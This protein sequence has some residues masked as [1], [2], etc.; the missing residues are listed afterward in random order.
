MNTEA[1]IKSTDFILSAAGN[2]GKFWLCV[3]NESGG[4]GGQYTRSE[5]TM[6]PPGWALHQ[7]C[8]HGQI[9]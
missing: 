8:G 9:T 5:R 3:E 4:Q 2:D 7:L 6:E 1:T